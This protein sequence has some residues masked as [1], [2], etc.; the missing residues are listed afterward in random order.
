MSDCCYQLSHALQDTVTLT[1]P[2]AAL[3]RAVAQLHAT[4][5]QF[6]Q[7]CVEQVLLLESHEAAA[8]THLQ[9]SQQ[10]QDIAQ[11][12]RVRLRLELDQAGVAGDA[13]FS[14][15]KV[16]VRPVQKVIVKQVTST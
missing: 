5:S 10:A 1:G 11:Q 9:A 16:Q 13:A 14:G 12:H 6:Q 15:S 7:G 3:P 4:C 2:E 8:F